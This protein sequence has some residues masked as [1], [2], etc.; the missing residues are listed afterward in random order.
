MKT[1]LKTVMIPAGLLLLAIAV[2]AIL[3]STQIE[4]LIRAQ[5]ETRISHILG[6]DMRVEKI[7]ILPARLGIELQRLAVKN[8]PSFKQ[9]DTLVCQRVLVRPDWRTLF[10]RTIV[11]N[12][13]ILNGLDVNLRYKVGEGT[14]LGYIRK[15]AANLAATQPVQAPGRMLLVKALRSAP[16]DFHMSSVLTADLPVTVHVEPFTLNNVGEGQ[17]IST[18]K[19]ASII[20]RTLM[21]EALTLKGILR[22]VVNLLREEVQ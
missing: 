3:L 15:Q 1:L 8:P 10:A 6:A 11:L 5:L 4:G 18:A 22:P 13:I 7:R 2:T 21:M 14:N 12:E 9:G 19:L 20:T 17:P 16:S